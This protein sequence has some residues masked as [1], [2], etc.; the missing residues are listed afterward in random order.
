MN[1]YVWDDLESPTWPIDSHWLVPKQSLKHSDAVDARTSLWASD[2]SFCIFDLSDA[3]NRAERSSPV[4]HDVPP[5]RPDKPYSAAEWEAIFND[6]V[7]FPDDLE[8]QRDG[9]WN[10]PDGDRAAVHRIPDPDSIECSDRLSPVSARDDFHVTQPNQMETSEDQCPWTSGAINRYIHEDDPMPVRHLDDLGCNPAELGVSAPTN[11][12]DLHV[13]A[14]QPSYLVSTASSTTEPDIAAPQCGK[15][16]SEQPGF[17]CFYC[18]RVL[19]T[20]GGRTQHIR[21]R[22]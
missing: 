12:S 8:I 19:L 9:W 11:R 21:A 1:E 20:Q 6:W 4:D 14:S 13:T 5:S 3:E 2:P 18:K 16:Q 17:P 22:H 10:P 7:S 15:V